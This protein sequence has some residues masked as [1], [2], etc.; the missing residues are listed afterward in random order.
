M[1][2]HEK[3]IG[4]CEPYS[5]G[6]KPDRP[7]VCIPDIHADPRA[8]LLSLK[9]AG[10]IS[11][12]EK[13]EWSVLPKATSVT[14]VLLGDL[15]DRG[16]SGMEVMTIIVALQQ[17]GIRMDIIM[18]NHEAEFLNDLEGDALTLFAR[19]KH[20]DGLLHE[21]WE[22]EGQPNETD[23]FK[24]RVQ[25][26]IYD[27]QGAAWKVLNSMQMFKRYG[28]IVCAH[29]G[30]DDHWVGKLVAD[31]PEG[32]DDF[33]G[34]TA[35]REK[36]FKTLY[37]K[38]AEGMYMNVHKAHDLNEMGVWGIVRGHE[39]SKMNPRLRTLEYEKYPDTSIIVFN[40]D[41]KIS[42]GFASNTGQSGW[43]YLTMNPDG[44]FEGGS[45]GNHEEVQLKSEH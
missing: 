11:I 7:I 9:E 2:G 21:L 12:N 8:L 35:V 14:V 16:Q 6:L 5:N 28:G 15:I 34:I 13:L 20:K 31:L 42:N 39:Q 3:D 32:K 41:A 1:V 33:H 45:G 36:M 27:T 24:K 19:A 37:L 30:I 22:K 29:A 10:V 17:A 43:A 23:A 18:G 25:H 44:T 4:V 38:E 26:L 40:V